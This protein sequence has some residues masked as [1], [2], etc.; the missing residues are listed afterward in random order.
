M[1]TQTTALVVALRWKWLRLMKIITAQHNVSG[2]L[3]VFTFNV[4]IYI[5][6]LGACHKNIFLVAVPT[7]APADVLDTCSPEV[8]SAISQVLGMSEAT[9]TEAKQPANDPATKTEAKQPANDPATKTEAKQPAYDPVT[10]ASLTSLPGNILSVCV[11]ALVF[12]AT[13]NFS[14]LFYFA[15]FQSFLL[16]PKR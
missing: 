14:C 13:N 15:S 16:L 7:T 11:V 6:K 3:L 5:Y 8:R 1:M 12:G 2:A 9:K 4:Y 10:M